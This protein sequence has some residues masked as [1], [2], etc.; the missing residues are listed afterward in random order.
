MIGF[1][2]IEPDVCSGRPIIKGTRISVST[3]LSY[4]SA[5]DTVDDIIK[6]HPELSRESI[7]ACLEYARRL[8]DIHVLVEKAS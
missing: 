1:I 8:G 2:E 3:V 4:L 5:G 7:L 6:A